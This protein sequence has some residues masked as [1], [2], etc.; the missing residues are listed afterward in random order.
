MR[1]IGAFLR[2]WYDFIVGDDWVIALGVLIALGLT[3]L[4]ADRGVT[5]WWVMPVAVIALLATSL[6]RALR[7]SS[8]DRAERPEP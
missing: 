7:E 1:Y 8:S 3:A 6:R 5:A 2:F 4:I